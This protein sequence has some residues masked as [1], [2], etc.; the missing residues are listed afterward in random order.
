M[1]RESGAPSNLRTL[2]SVFTGSPAFAGDD[3][4]WREARFG[5]LASPSGEGHNSARQHRSGNRR[6]APMHG[7]ITSLAAACV[8]VPLAAYA[9]PLK[10]VEVSAPAV[11]CVFHL[12]C[13]LLV[14]DTTG[15]ILLPT[16]NPGDAGLH[17]R[18]FSAEP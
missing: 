11:N 14:N 9:Q 13:R 2:R 7:R 10:V 17:S 6:E 8:F 3:D 4:A 5:N 15:N 12:D 1:P 16:I 18:V